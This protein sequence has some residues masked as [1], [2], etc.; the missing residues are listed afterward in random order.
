MSSPIILTLNLEED[1]ILLNEGV[2]NALDWPRQVQLLINPEAKQFALRACTVDADQAVVV[3]PDETQQVEISGRT[4]LKKISHLV[5][6]EDRRPR[7]CYGE[8]MP[9]YQ[10][11][12]FDLTEAKPLEVEEQ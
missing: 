9:A 6:W 12:R 4:L 1:S 10:A 2:L 5:G 11:V 7:M 3:E 8:Y